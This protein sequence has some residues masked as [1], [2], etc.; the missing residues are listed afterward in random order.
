MPR[1]FTVVPAIDRA[2]LLAIPQ[3]RQLFLAAVAGLRDGISD[4]AVADAIDS[5]A[6]A[7]ILDDEAWGVF[8]QILGDAFVPDGPLSKAMASVIKRT[9]AEAPLLGLKLDQGAIRNAASRWL[10]RHGADRVRQITESTRV[11]VKAVLEEGFK[12]PLSRREVARRLA[13]VKGFGLTEHQGQ[14]LTRWMQRQKASGKWTSL[15]ERE[16]QYRIDREFG[17]RVRQRANTV[18]HTEAYNAGNQARRETYRAAIDQGVIAAGDYVLEWITRG[19]NVC[20]RCEAL[21]RKT[22][23]I[24]DGIFVSEPVKEGKYAG[25]IIRVERPTV[26][27]RCYC[28][29]RSI[30]RSDAAEQPVAKA[31]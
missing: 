18:A 12:G 1:K 25:Q 26:H 17:R 7:A 15:T 29:I 13:R 8:A 9:S 24:E 21:D 31:A 23:E 10:D 14:D 4:E 27:P 22:A 11:G 6:T 28:T 20:P 30:A 2:A 16:I 5:G 19:F 3:V